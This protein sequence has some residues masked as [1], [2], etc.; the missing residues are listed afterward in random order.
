LAKSHSIARKHNR[1]SVLPRLT[2]NFDLIKK[3]N[4]GMGIYLNNAGLGPA[5]LSQFTWLV[6]DKIFKVK[7]S[8][9]NDELLKYLKLDSIKHHY[10]IH[11]AGSF[12][13]SGYNDFLIIFEKPK[14]DKELIE[15]GNKLSKIKVKL[16]Y[17]S[18]YE[19][20]FTANYSAS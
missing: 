4:M 17:T 12:I 14:T 11:D 20:P 1:L 10:C 16:E 18:I 8:K 5:I 6:D 13:E 9:D 2:I 3:T 19:E 15:L 7:S